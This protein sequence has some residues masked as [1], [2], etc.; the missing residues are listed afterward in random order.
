VQYG[1]TSIPCTMAEGPRTALVTGEFDFLGQLLA[2]V[3]QIRDKAAALPYM[4]NFA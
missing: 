1:D 3:K 2:G 4:T